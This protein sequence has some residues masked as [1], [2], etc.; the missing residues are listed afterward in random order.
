MHFQLRFHTERDIA[1]KIFHTSIESR[2]SIIS[3]KRQRNTVT[4][5]EKAACCTGRHKFSGK[6]IITADIRVSHEDLKPG[7]MLTT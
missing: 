3:E 7:V 2:R 5:S 6:I 1:Q 4:R